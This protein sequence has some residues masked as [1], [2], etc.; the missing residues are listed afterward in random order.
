MMMAAM[1]PPLSPLSLSLA[2]GDAA[3]VF[4]AAESVAV[5]ANSVKCVTAIC[6]TPCVCTRACAYV[7]ACVLACMFQTLHT[8]A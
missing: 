3:G 7:R 8:Q 5:M 1:T 2:G 4:V 6:R